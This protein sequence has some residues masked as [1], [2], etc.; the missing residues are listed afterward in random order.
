MGF[1]KAEFYDLLVGGVNERLD[2]RN[3]TKVVLQKLLRGGAVYLETVGETEGFHAKNESEVDGLSLP[4]L[5]VGDKRI[6]DIED[7]RRSFTVNIFIFV[8]RL[9]ERLLLGEAGYD[10]VFY[11]GIIEVNE[12][13]A[14]AGD[15]MTPKVFRNILEIWSRTCKAARRHMPLKER[16]VDYIGNGIKRR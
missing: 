7:N 10:A 9:N 13:V 16:R 12:D 2:F 14:R 4:P 6:R 3:G 1:D 15:E 11:L 5:V 8:E